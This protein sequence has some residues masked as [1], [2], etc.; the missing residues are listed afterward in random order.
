MF[1]YG[2]TQIISC[3]SIT[4]ANNVDN[5]NVLYVNLTLSGQECQ[6]KIYEVIS[7]HSTYTFFTF[8]WRYKRFGT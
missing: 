4:F 6:N 8:Y 1:I 7:E 5:G 3:L 2:T